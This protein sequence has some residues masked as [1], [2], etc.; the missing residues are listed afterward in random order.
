MHEPT[1]SLSWVN[2]LKPKCVIDAREMVIVT[3]KVLLMS[4]FLQ[5]EKVL[6]VLL[7]TFLTIISI[8]IHIAARP[9]ENRCVHPSSIQLDCSH[10]FSFVA[11]DACSSNGIPSVALVS[12]LRL[13]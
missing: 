7:A 12:M 8:G 5:F 4:I 2:V 13:I 9:Y 10:W 6:A 11:F 1:H 3:R